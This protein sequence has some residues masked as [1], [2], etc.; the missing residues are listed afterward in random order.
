[1]AT[2]TGC[3]PVITGSIP[4]DLPK[5][6][7]SQVGKAAVFEAANP[8][9][10]PGGAA[11]RLCWNGRHAGLRSSCSESSPVGSSPTGRTINSYFIGSQSVSRSLARVQEE[12][13]E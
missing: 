5:L 13:V 7:L 11:M 1:M 8:G 10:S 3:G 4:V 6:P 2:A 9:S 12:M